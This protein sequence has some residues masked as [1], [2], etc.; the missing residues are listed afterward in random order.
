VLNIDKM[1]QYQLLF[2]NKEILIQSIQVLYCGLA[3]SYADPKKRKEACSLFKDMVESFF[4]IKFNCEELELLTEDEAWVILSKE[5]VLKRLQNFK[6]PLVDAIQELQVDEDEEIKVNKKWKELLLNGASKV[7]NNIFQVTEFEVKEQEAR[8]I[9]MFNSSES[10]LLFGGQEFYSFF[11]HLHCLYERLKVAHDYIGQAFEQEL[12][13]KPEIYSAF[14][15]FIKENKEQIREERYGKIFFPSVVSYTLGEIKTEAYED[16][17]KWL[18]GSRAYILFTIDKL[19]RSVHITCNL[20]LS[21]YYNTFLVI[22]LL[23]ILCSYFINHELLLNLNI[24]FTMGV[25]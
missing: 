10:N 17:C 2:D 22:L 16:L 8:F 20:R 21:K 3:N 18:I 23:L 19:T 4:G 15:S 11:R 24:F 5:F 9:P 13:C 14:S 25:C 1:P 7:P 6:K 12:E